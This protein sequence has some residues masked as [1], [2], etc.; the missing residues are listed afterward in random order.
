MDKETLLKRLSDI[1]WDDFEVK[2]AAAELPKNVWET[3][4]TFSNTA[5]GWIVLGMLQ[6]GK[7]FDITGVTNPEKI[8]QDFV[9]TLRSKNKFNALVNLLMHA[10]YFSP[11]KPRI[12]VFTNRIEFENPGAFPRPVEELLKEDVSI[13]RNPVIAKLCRCAKFCENAG[14][15]FD[16]MLVWEKETNREVHFEN[17]LDKTKVTFMLKDG[18][19]DMLGG[20]TSGRTGGQT[21]Q[22]SEIQKKIIWQIAQN[23]KVSRRDL[24]TILGI[25]Q[26]AV[27]KH[28]EK[29]KELGLIMR[30]GT[31]GGRWIIIKPE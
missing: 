22:L 30:E 18:K 13:P 3:V 9:T 29:L 2:E 14:Y 5:G 6:Q 12:R 23:P 24:A 16:K 8:E 28:F 21:L 19:V 17:R 31:F 25:N 27:Q 11:M 7:R 26:S 1:E 15:G 20:Q 4:S 10:D